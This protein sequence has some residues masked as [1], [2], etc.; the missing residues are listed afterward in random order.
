MRTSLTKWVHVCVCKL[1]HL[2]FHTTP[3]SPV[4]SL[5]EFSSVPKSRQ[6]TLASRLLIPLALVV[7][8]SASAAF[9][10]VQYVYDELGRLVQ[11]INPSGT[12]VQYTY[13]AAGNI[14][15]VRQLATTTPSITEFTPNAGPV[16][17]TV[18]IYGTGFSTTASQNTVKFN[19]TTTTVSTATATQLTVTVPSGATTGTISVTTSGGTATSAQ[20]FTVTAGSPVP[21]V[22]GFTPTIGSTGTVVT[23]N[24]AN[25]DP[26]PTNDR[27]RFNGTNAIVTGATASQITSTVPAGA[28]SGKVSV[29]TVFG[30]GTSSNDFFVPPSGYT[31]ADV[32]AIG[33]TTVG[34]SPAT[35]SVPTAGKVGMFLFDG[36]QGQ[37]LGLGIN[38]VTGSGTIYIKKPD[39]QNLMPSFGFN[40]SG[41]S[42]NLPTLTATGAYAIVVVA[43]A[44]V[45]LTI[46][47]S[48]DI[49]GSVAV[50]GPT[51]SLSSSRIGQNGRFN[52]TGNQGQTLGLGV[53]G[54][55][56]TPSGGSI[57]IKVWNPDGTVFV[58]CGNFTTLGG[59]CNIP[60]I[61]V[62]GNYTIFVDPVGAA[63]G[64]LTLTLSSDLTGTMTA[65][66]PA[67]TFNLPRQ[68]QNARYIFSGIAGHQINLTAG[69]SAFSTSPVVTM[70]KPAA[71]GSASSTNGILWTGSMASGSQSDSQSVPLTGTYIVFVEAPGLVTGSITLA[72]TEVT[73]VTG[74][75]NVDAPAV[76]VM[77]TKAAQ[78]VRL[79]FAG[80]AGQNLSLG[81]VNVTFAGGT[82]CLADSRIL[83]PNGSQ[84]VTFQ[85]FSP[86]TSTDL[87]T[88][89]ETGT[90]TLIVDPRTTCTMNVN[91]LLSSPVAVSLT[92]DGPAV[93]ASTLREG[94]DL[95]FNFV[96][97]AGQNL[98][99]GITG[100]V[101][102]P[103][104]TN[105]ASILIVKPDGTGLVATSGSATD[106]G[107]S[108]ALPTSGIYTVVISP[109][110]T[111]TAS[112]TLTL[113]SDLNAGALVIDGTPAIVTTN[114]PGQNARLTFGG[115]TGQ[116]LTLAVTGSTIT[117]GVA[118]I[119]KPDGSNLASMNFSPA[120]NSVDFPAL[121]ITGSYTVFVDP[122]AALTGNL[123]LTLSSDTSAAIVADGSAVDAVTTRP[124]QRTRLTFSATAGQGMGIGI[125]GVTFSPANAIVYAS[126]LKPDGSSLTDI[127][128]SSSGSDGIFTPPTSGIYTVLVDPL[129]AATYSMT[130][131]LSNDLNAGVLAVNGASATVT[132]TRP[133][134]NFRQTFSGNAGQNLS[135]AF[136]GASGYNNLA[137][138]IFK[139]DGATLYSNCCGTGTIDLSA[140]PVTGTYTLLVDQRGPQTGTVTLTLSADVTG[141]IAINGA[142][143]P[144][145]IGRIGQRARLTFAGTAGQNLRAN[146][147]GVNI[148]A[149]YGCLLEVDI[150]NPSGSTLVSRAQ[151][152][153]PAGGFDI[154]TLPS[155]GNYDVLIDPRDACATASLN[156]AVVTR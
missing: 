69:T 110:G 97:T 127:Q 3:V 95:R 53:S 76:T 14:T 11:V 39:G 18:T 49:T 89:P 45:S 44:A 151:I 94:Q 66:G 135:L 64:T 55:T 67:I 10:D 85:V 136:T 57:A 61:P 6:S 120:G 46:T 16:G 106:Q 65:D 12:S 71:D 131:T 38:G 21:T 56:A 62:N 142:T 121:L 102:N 78:N 86:A 41:T 68:G 143:V 146:F 132:T 7:G 47:L 112:A 24:G 60:S 35:F 5:P 88:L 156:A 42:A 77:T 154:P 17:A 130:L 30:T 81:F 26:S 155:T 32:V 101:F 20:T 138:T 51:S 73:D 15:A 70:F 103:T 36:I 144:V 92:I 145:S 126:I 139:P 48:P 128:I 119:Y 8:L 37:N 27:V 124:G 147:T 79:T 72:L 54:L 107:L 117:N 82:G 137:S 2:L 134:Q 99:L 90:Y 83:R 22:T 80:T 34:A 29:A 87:P 40:S 153:S 74:T 123:T 13:D 108:F 19:G 75:I 93:T 122:S 91:V 113:S 33:R 109:P 58:D 31:T 1:R 111:S 52:F 114:R 28:G 149:V 116:R 59:T 141:A 125:T 133:G 50:D 25:F 129:G 100:F 63:A 118:Y 43:S 140:L 115:T 152:S 98:G 105:Q 84:F 96:G 9:A 150:R 148:P 23:I 4:A 104:N